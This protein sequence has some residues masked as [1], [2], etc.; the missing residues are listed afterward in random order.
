MVLTARQG[1]LL[2]AIGSGRELRPLV[3][4][5]GA[6]LDDNLNALID[7]ELV[8]ARLTSGPPDASDTPRLPSMP[9]PKQYERGRLELATED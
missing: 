6:D 8:E 3:E 2:R 9:W 4:R 7:A 1:E 5:F